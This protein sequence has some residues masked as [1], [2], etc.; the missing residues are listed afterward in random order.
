MGALMSFPSLC[1]SALR[2]TGKVPRS[3]FSIWIYWSFSLPPK[4][5]TTGTLPSIH[6]SAWWPRCV[7]AEM[8]ARRHILLLRK[9]LS[10]SR[11]APDHREKKMPGPF[12]KGNAKPIKQKQLVTSRLNLSMPELAFPP[13][14][15]SG[16]TCL[17]RQLHRHHFSD[18]G[19]SRGLA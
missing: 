6:A 17:R 8:T 4:C 13:L 2:L 5:S 16:E 3:L 14:F 10:C 11:P 18:C 1:L 12:L 9:N 19:G 7:L 15:H